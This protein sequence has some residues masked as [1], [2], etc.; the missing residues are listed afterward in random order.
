MTFFL[1]ISLQVFA[2]YQQLL[3]K[4]TKKIAIGKKFMHFF[5]HQVV[6]E[7]PWFPA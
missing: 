7:F 6:A 2:R 4:G 5:C 3:C 1:L